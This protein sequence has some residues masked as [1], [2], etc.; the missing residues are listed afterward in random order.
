MNVLKYSEW[1]DTALTL[2]LISQMLGKAKLTRMEPQPEWNHTLL[3]LNADG[4]TTGLIPNGEKSFSISLMIKEGKV[5]ASGID[6]RTSGFSFETGK[7][8]SEYY[9]LFNRML[10]D[11]MCETEICTVPME[12]NTRTPFEDDKV[13]R[14][15]DTQCALTFFQMSTFAHNALLKFV[16][17]YRGKKILPSFFWGTFDISAVLFSGKEAPFPGNGVIE[18]TAF[19][20]QM[21]EF[22]FWPGDDTIDEPSFFILPYPFVT[23][24]LSNTNIKPDKA[25]YSKEKSEYFITLRDVMN[26]EDPEAALLAFFKSG[27]EILTKEEHW[28]NVEWLVKPLLITKGSEALKKQK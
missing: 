12:M 21:I 18:K 26:Y 17:A 25:F 2:H 3:Q 22:G 9:A 20:E 8:I 16:S 23:K 5:V 7:S 27:F 4:F 6:G 10:N 28:D 11:V 14:E 24:D 13:K 19:D 15:Y 1:K